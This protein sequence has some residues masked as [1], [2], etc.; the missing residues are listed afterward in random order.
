M[1]E[2]LKN[3]IKNLLQKFNSG[4]T[5]ESFKEIEGLVKKNNDNINLIFTYA[6]MANKLNF[7][8]KAI[9]GFNYI[10]IQQPLNIICLHNLYSIHLKNNNLDKAIYLINKIIEINPKHYEA[11]RD[12]AYIQYLQNDSQNALKN[13]EIALKKNHKDFFGLNI[14]G[15]LLYSTNK[16]HEAIKIFE[17]A[18]QINKNYSDS[19]NNLGNCYFEL[20]DLDKAF[21]YFKKSYKINPQFELAL[22]NIG[23]V[24]SL[25]DKNLTAINFYKKAL[26]INPNKNEIYSNIA[27]CYCRLKDV[28]NA[29][30]HFAKAIALNPKDYELKLSYAYLLIFNKEFESAWDFFDS[31]L[32]IS[33]IKKMNKTYENIKDKLT[34][35]RSLNLSDK[36]LVIK[37]QGIG[38]EILFSSMYRDLLQKFSNV[39]IETDPR[40]KEIFKR[41]FKKNIFYSFGHFSNNINTL[42]IFNKIIYAGSLTKYFR[43]NEK[44]FNGSPYL[45]Y[46]YK[47]YYKLKSEIEKLGSKPKIG[48]SWK[49]IVNIYGKLNNK[50][51]KF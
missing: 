19:Y 40:L 26:K 13:I 41:S 24:L 1:S 17:K 29:K 49:S 4:K 21:L 8:S 42:N 28:K 20:E 44:K 6:V 10:L 39:K 43:K 18:I 47:K 16:I 30:I 9:K 15:L 48:I 45:N 12:K 11:L 14:K 46:D 34:K 37:E 23:N 32:L 3:T 51:N 25:K 36:I 27:M 38:D 5:N 22:I 50:T 31:R 7:V 33:R 35:T 2:N